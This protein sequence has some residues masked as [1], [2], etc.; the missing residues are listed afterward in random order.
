MFL[1]SVATFSKP[2]PMSDII[3]MKVT[4]HFHSIATESYQVISKNESRHKTDKTFSAGFT[5]N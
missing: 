1:K 5:D 2:L 3:P 4:V